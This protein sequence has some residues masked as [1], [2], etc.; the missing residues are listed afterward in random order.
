MNQP[1]EL[2]E[3]ELRLLQIESNAIAL[4]EKFQ[5]AV[6]AAVDE[7]GKFDAEGKFIGFNFHGGRADQLLKVSSAYQSFSAAEA[8]R[9]TSL[10]PLPAPQ[11]NLM[12]PNAP[13]APKPSV[14]H[15]GP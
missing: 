11:V 14:S 2:T 6:E 5:A 1:H 4:T 9:R 10:R 13:V 8:S 7:C 3:A 12:R 15:D